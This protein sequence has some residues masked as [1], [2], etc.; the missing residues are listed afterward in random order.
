MN[1]KHPTYQL[2][3]DFPQKLDKFILKFLSDGF[4]HFADEFQKIDSFVKQARCEINAGSKR[5]DISLRINPKE[6]YLLELTAFKI[7]DEINREEFNRRKKTLIIMPDCLSIH[8]KECD[9]VET[10][11]GSVCRRCQEDCQAFQI[12]ELARKYKA[13]VLFSKRSLA[14]QLEYHADKMGD[15]AVIGVACIMMLATGMRKANEVDIPARGV[16]LNFTGCDHWND[17]PFASQFNL[18]ALEAILEE[19]YGQSD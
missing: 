17:N 19:K 18:D 13:K 3:K 2:G 9:K 1:S 7:Y 8:E 15:M 10:K 6:K 11:Y 4:E 16:L 14:E 12:T 5:D